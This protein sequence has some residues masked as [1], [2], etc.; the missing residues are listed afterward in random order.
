MGHDHHRSQICTLRELSLCFV[1]DGQM[2][3]YTIIHCGI[4]HSAALPQLSGYASALYKA[5]IDVIIYM[6]IHI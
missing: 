3:L 1:R 5:Y 6:L 2:R 4:P